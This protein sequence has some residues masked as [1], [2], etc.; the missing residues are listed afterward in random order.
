[1]AK[2]NYLLWLAGSSVA[3]ALAWHFLW[4]ART[5]AGQPPLAYLKSDNSG[6]FKDQFN[7]AAANARMVLL[8]SPT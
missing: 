3:L 5:P 8:L 4:S 7:R 2:K 6:Q 1:M